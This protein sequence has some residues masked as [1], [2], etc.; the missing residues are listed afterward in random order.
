MDKIKVMCFGLQGFGNDLLQSLS[1]NNHVQLSGIYTREPIYPFTYYACE[2]IETIAERM[3]VSVHY[4]PMRGDWDCA[5]ADLAITSSF[6]RIFQSNHLSNFRY[7]INIHPSLL[8]KYRGATPTNW[9]I[10]NGERIV[11]LTAHLIDEGIDSGA[12]LFRRQLLNPFLND[13][14]L[15]KALSFLSRSLVKDIITYFPNYQE[16]AV[17]DIESSFPART[18][19]DALAKLSDFETIDDLIFHIQAFTNY[20][21]PK[22]DIDGRVFIVDYNNPELAINI[23]LANNNFELLGYY[24]TINEGSD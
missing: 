8:P 21:M 1:D 18:E 6:H 14:Q 10:R 9:M 13:A 23:E 22:L 12:I 19:E 11:G 17:N 3:G 24:K 20:P 5:P 16:I 4:V 2:S 15:R 7:A